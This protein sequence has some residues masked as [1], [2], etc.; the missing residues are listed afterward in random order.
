MAMKVNQYRDGTLNPTLHHSTDPRSPLKFKGQA[1]VDQAW[2]DG[3]FGP[4]WLLKDAP[5]ISEMGFDSKEEM[6]EAV[7]RDPRYQEL[8]LDSRKSRK[9]LL[10]DIAAFEES[11]DVGGSEG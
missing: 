7:E 8:S 1:A 9:I 10:A 3:W 2:E 5:W 11:S 4:P 6:L